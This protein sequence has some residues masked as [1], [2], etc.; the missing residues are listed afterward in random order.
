MRYPCDCMY[1]DTPWLGRN[2]LDDR[3]TTAIVLARSNSSLISSV[4]ILDTRNSVVLRTQPFFAGSIFCLN[5]FSASLRM[6]SDTSLLDDRFLRSFTSK[7]FI[8]PSDRSNGVRGLK[9]RLRITG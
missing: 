3:P 7:F 9:T 8:N 4:W 1:A 6:V 2:G 5:I